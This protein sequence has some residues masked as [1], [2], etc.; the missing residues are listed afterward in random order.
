MR[1]D[2]TV[3]GGDYTRTV[4]RVS[5]SGST[6]ALTL[7]VGAEHL[8]TGIQVSYTPGME[9]KRLRDVPG[10]EALGLSREPVTND[11][12]DTTSP[13]VSSLVISSNPGSVQTYAAGE[14]I[15]LTVTFSETVVVTGTLRLRLR[16]GSRTRTAGYLR[17]TDTA[18]LVFGYEVVEG[19]EDT[20]GVSMEANSLTRNVGTI[21]DGA[22]NNALLSHDGL[23]ADAR[24]KVDGVRPSFLSA[25]VDGS[26]LTL[27]Y[28]EALDVRSTP[29]PGDFTVQADGNGR[30]VAE[31][32]VSGST[33][34]LTLDPAVEHGETGI[35]VSYTPEMK[36][37]RDVP[38]NEAQ[39][40]SRE[41]VRNDTPDTTSPEVSSVAISSNPG[42]DQTYA[43]GD[44]IE[45]MVAFSETV[46]V[47]GTPQL[48]LELGG[49]TRTATYEGGT[50]TAALVFAY[51]VADGESDTDGVGV[52]E[53]SL[54]GGTIRD[55][56]R[57][58]AKLDHEGL[59]ADSGHKV[60]GVKP[61]L[62]ASGGAVVNGTT[63]TLTYD[64][65]L[66]GSSTPDAGDFTVS[67]G[68]YTR[69]VTRVSVS[70][71]TVALTLNVG[72]EHLEAGIQVSYTPGANPIQDAAGNEVEALSREAVRNDTPDTSPPEVESL[73]ISS[74][75]GSDQT[76]AAGDEIEV[77]VRFSETVVVTGTL[78][79]RLRVGSRNRTAG[80][81]RGTDTAAVVFG[82][83]VA[84]GDEDT[85]GVSMEAN[86]LDAER[87]DRSRTAS[88]NNADAV[89][90]TDCD[91]PNARHKVDGVR[92]AFVSAAVDGS[93]LTL[94]YGEALDEGSR[95][96]SGDFTVEVDG[97][98]AKRFGSV[99]QRERGDADAQ[100]GG[101][102]RGY[103]DPGELHGSDRGGG[104]PAPG[105]GGQRGSRTEQPVGDQHHGS[106]KHGA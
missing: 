106:A 86:S 14:V 60:D 102:A 83:E 49:G 62:A 71:S 76:Y 26:S 51:E 85:D 47:T 92:P 87:G 7:N 8:E 97:E 38:G 19:D 13:T 35:L 66:D 6:V 99:G 89:P 29:V 64:E 61:E 101:R 23:A 74:N 58:S 4:T 42:S 45:V 34:T 98:R 69:T 94:T 55:E 95:P 31:V 21:R 30:T 68:D 91:E 17:G 90:S 72:A 79:L 25:A 24:H 65:P 2:F 48:R 3:S 15:E 44:E 11:T 67:G 57:N 37:L 104:E 56:A 80:Y 41:S 12:P 1:G 96:A 52:E 81:L 53:D 54:S 10:N 63:L 28:G 50:G 39:S 32:L 16:V 78:R 103:G 36:P 82:Y 88:D 105:R 77:T 59:A 20:D 43:A 33:V 9:R 22:D 40:L 18:A 100:S 70:G 84:E 73:A 27:T 46:E 5:V 93:A 75:P